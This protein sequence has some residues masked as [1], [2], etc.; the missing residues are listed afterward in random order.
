MEKKR[1]TSCLLPKVERL[2]RLQRT[3]SLMAEYWSSNTLISDF[4]SAIYS[5]PWSTNKHQLK[6]V[7]HCVASKM[8]SKSACYYAKHVVFLN[9]I[10]RRNLSELSVDQVDI[11]RSYIVI[12]QASHLS[13]FL[14]SFVC[15]FVCLTVCL[16]EC[17]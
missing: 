4:A 7:L 9:S 16:I 2:K 14:S 3:V 8:Y 13:N 12:S 6:K 15:N 17:V 11:Y 10:S 5:L 1:R